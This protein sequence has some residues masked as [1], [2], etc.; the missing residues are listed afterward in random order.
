MSDLTTGSMNP[1][2]G[3]VWQGKIGVCAFK[4]DRVLFVRQKVRLFRSG[5]EPL[6]RLQAEGI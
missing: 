2:I 4:S 1:E 3:G 6:V 5:I